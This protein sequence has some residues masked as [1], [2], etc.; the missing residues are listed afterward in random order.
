MRHGVFLV[1][2]FAALGGCQTMKEQELVPQMQMPAKP[3]STAR[4]VLFR[5]DALTGSPSAA[6]EITVN[7][8][9]LGRLG[10]E[11]LYIHDVPPGDQV[12]HLD[13]KSPRLNSR[14]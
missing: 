2:I 10:D 8:Q 6:P 1:V 13:R 3:A 4:I 9:P 5:H 12:A 11:G 7:G 14:H